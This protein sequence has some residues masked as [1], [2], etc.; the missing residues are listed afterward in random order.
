MKNLVKIYTV[1]LQQS[2]ETLSGSKR[3]I[4]KVYNKFGKKLMSKYFCTYQYFLT[5]K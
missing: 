1:T 5:G 2:L 4:L 3:D